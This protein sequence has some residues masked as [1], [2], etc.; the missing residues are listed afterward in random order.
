MKT[1][2]LTIIILLFVSFSCDVKDNNEAELDG[3]LKIY[4]SGNFDDSFH[5]LDFQETSDGGF[6]ILGVKDKNSV[7]L[8]KTDVDGVFE[9]EINGESPYVSPI[10]NLLSYGSNFVFFCMDENTFEIYAMEVNPSAQTLTP[11]IYYEDETYALQAIETEDGGFLLHHFNRDGRQ[12][13][14]RK[15]AANLEEEWD[16]NANPQNIEEIERTII[17]NIEVA[18]PNIPYFNGEMAD[19]YFVNT[20]SRYHYRTLFFNSSGSN[21]GKISET[22]G[23]EAAINSMVHLDDNFF[24]LSRYDLDGNIYLNPRIEIDTESDIRV[25]DLEEGYEFAEI[26]IRAEIKV[27]VITIEGTNYT[28]YAC[29]TKNGQIE[30]IIFDTDSGDFVS[31]YYVGH[32]NHYSIS[33]FESTSDGGLAILAQ[34]TTA[35]MFNQ[36]AII[37]LTDTEL[38]EI[39]KK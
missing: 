6:L 37:K 27:E 2:L 13:K 33:R 26:D 1:K 15:L 23:D 24:A 39:I 32:N 7:Y 30:L 10:A 19:G 9:W 20:F 17:D 11:L 25:S 35:G 3:Y 38:K 29:D 12:I 14:I 16:E 8:L 31:T 18:D 5:P 36:I 4:S 22:N 28:V 34:T 21:T